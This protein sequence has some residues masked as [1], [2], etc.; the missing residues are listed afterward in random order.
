VLNWKALDYPGSPRGYILC[1][2]VFILVINI[3]LGFVSVW[4]PS[5]ITEI[6]G[7]IDYMGHIGGALCGIFLGMAFG[8]PMENN[9]LVLGGNVSSQN[10]RNLLIFISFFTERYVQKA[11]IISTIILL[12]YF[13]AGFLC[14]YFLRH[15]VTYIF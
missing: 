10:I 6:Q 3:V 13:T 4:S 12:I 11:K 9:V 1:F 2:M 8:P 15:P 5:D 14:F 7:N